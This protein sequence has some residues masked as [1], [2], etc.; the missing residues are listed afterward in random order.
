MS[1]LPSKE[2]NQFMTRDSLSSVAGLD[3][4]QVDTLRIWLAEQ[5]VAAEYAK[6][7]QGGHIEASVPLQRVFVD[8]PVTDRQNQMDAGSTPHSYFIDQLMRSSTR[9]LT[10]GSDI[11]N[12]LPDR[13]EQ[14][15]A[16]RLNAT[17][18]AR[19]S[20]P[21]TFGYI[22][23]GGPGQGK[24]TLGQLACQ[25]H[26]AAALID[27]ADHLEMRAK[28]VLEQ[29]ANPEDGDI[30]EALK[31]PSDWL[32]PLSI[33]LPDLS[34]WLANDPPPQ[35]P[36]TDEQ[37]PLLLQFI[38]S[39][40]SAKVSKL[41][42]ATIRA[43]TLGRPVLLF[44]DG[45]D[46]VGST[47]DRARLVASVRE[48]IDYLKVQ[49]KQF[50]I[51]ATTRP[52]G[53]SGELNGIGVPLQTC[54]LVPLDVATALS[55]ARR[56][57]SAKLQG[58]DLQHRVLSRLEQAATEPAT[59]RLM[60]SPL[61]VTI[62]AALAQQGSA[63]RER[64]TLFRSYFDII[65]RREIERESYAAALLARQRGH[66]EQ[67]HQRVA[68]TLQVTSEE[69]GGASAR[70]SRDDLSI[71]IET[72]LQE[73][74]VAA[75]VR[76][77]LV[78]DILN[79]AEHRLVLL[80]EPEPG[81]FGF[82]IRSL[83]EFMA[84]WALTDG[85]DE[86]VEARLLQIAPA[87]MFR[88]ILLFIASRFF[89]ENH[90]LR[91]LIAE[92]ICPHLNDQKLS[93]LLSLTYA[94][95]SLALE[96]LEEGAVLS[97]PKRARALMSH[98][99]QLLYLPPSFEHVRIAQIANDDTRDLLLVSIRR[100]F[101]ASRKD[102]AIDPR[103]AWICLTACGPGQRDE[104][105]KL[106]NEQWDLTEDLTPIIE[107]LLSNL[108]SVDPWLIERVEESASRISPMIFLQLLFDSE[109]LQ[110]FL[111]PSPNTWT[112]LILEA[113][114]SLNAIS[115]VWVIPK[116]NNSRYSIPDH[117]P[118]K[119]WLPLTS[120]A[121]FLHRPSAQSL[122]DSLQCIIE[123]SPY[124]D[125]WEIST[126]VPWPLAA[127]L[128]WAS[129][130]DDLRY[131]KELALKGELGDTDQWLAAQD[132][133]SA[134]SFRVG[135]LNVLTTYTKDRPF[136]ISLLPLCPPFYASPSTW[137]YAS[138]R[139]A[140][141]VVPLTDAAT[142]FL[143]ADRRAAREDLA[144]MC[145]SLIDFHPQIE[146]LDPVEASQ[147]YHTVHH[148]RGTKPVGL[149]LSSWIEI[150]TN[151]PEKVVPPFSGFIEAA[152]DNPT[153]SSLLLLALKEMAQP[154]HLLETDGSTQ[155][156]S[157]FR[158]LSAT[159]GSVGFSDTKG[160]VY[161]ALI[162]RYAGDAT[163]EESLTVVNHVAELYN[164]LS[165]IL[166]DRLYFP[167]APSERDDVTTTILELLLLESQKRPW[168][169]SRDHFLSYLA[170]RSLRAFRSQLQLST[171]WNKLELPHPFPMSALRSHHFSEPR[172][173]PVILNRLE[174]SDV[175]GIKHL[176]LEFA[177]DVKEFGQWIVLLGPNGAGKTSI[178]RA[179]VLACRNL[180]DPAIWPKGAFSTRWIRAG[181]NNS[182]QIVAHIDGL[183]RTVQ[184]RPAS[185]GMERF[186]QQ[187]EFGR[188]PMFPVFAYGCRRGSALGG[189]GRAVDTH[190]DGGPEVATLFDE[191]AS[192]IH[193]ETWLIQ[194]EGD[195]LKN[196][197]SKAVYDSICA[198]L[199]HL[200]NIDEVKVIDRRLW[201]TERGRPAVLLEAMSDGYLTT[202]GWFVDLIA[203]WIELSSR[204]GSGIQPDFMSS[205]VG[206]VL[207][208]EIDLHLHP[209]WQLNVIRRTRQLLPRMSFIVTT[210]NPL[211]IVGAHPQE[212]WVLTENQGEIRVRRGQE[213]PMLLTGGQIF[214]QYFGIES[215]FP[216]AIGQKINRYSYLT[217]NPART[218]S[219]EVEM[220]KLQEELEESGVVT[221]WTVTP[222]DPDL[223]DDISVFSLPTDS[224]K[225]RT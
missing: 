69:E 53:Y 96:T 40:A 85:R 110:T 213:A 54:Y 112:G 98:A 151:M 51:I 124:P 26:R 146:G 62:L 103:G 86:V 179:V 143:T 101:S 55:Y 127:C 200:L 139:N 178:L 175:R 93:P 150:V 222:S 193:A 113:I 212:I 119:S 188:A 31:L 164:E 45:F 132:T 172:R 165:A 107:S 118:P 121:Q 115:G 60:T 74:E 21:E 16:V 15:D 75:D 187:P 48:F 81:Q 95:A 102:H 125:W 126:S 109:N 198:A 171:V 83:Q 80:V 163:H 130:I 25:L 46:E 219:E 128:R 111:S 184:V 7:G 28:E 218:A 33:P 6:L 138:P 1:T 97:Q 77:Q 167:I 177:H 120:I 34:V 99:S 154:S 43:A 152:V 169:L 149:P 133:W 100:V 223:T 137:A 67:V 191:G 157:L 134:R 22:L 49:S 89:A 159:L 23:I 78:T 2:P 174:L 185:G 29:I 72:V 158:K 68:L 17:L 24:S 13:D 59:A 63:P 52:Q 61:Q 87:P 35:R 47:E 82:E 14:T 18:P 56:L 221:D 170:Q 9:T 76:K 203:R 4:K 11:S 5:L 208:D 19:G 50:Q 27:E 90:R 166:S 209:L 197:N 144:S 161:A 217:G 220:V 30:M 176:S 141:E 117:L 147:W 66:I 181:G 180:R 39:R 58:A 140:Q 155:S 210:H 136:D 204:E 160:A 189:I 153:N 194:W 168:N 135:I 192:L 64:W 186:D 91:D 123:H 148:F 129:G 131:A 70:I 206:L 211:T 201:I 195:S 116:V 156:A 20:R 44:L 71:I 196:P 73:D 79:A 225:P 216:S 182:A 8:L 3:A 32:L 57:V 145:I 207:I 142:A 199:C 108:H 42:L 214:R 12:H 215:I 190:A 88:N 10:G 114:G 224:D 92:R 122:A 37:S 38:V 36:S 202:L 104:V 94:G 162:R 105:A 173:L 183:Q 41:D 65:Y 205:M 84:A 106:W